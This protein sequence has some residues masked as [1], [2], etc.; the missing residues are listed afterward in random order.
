MATPDSRSPG[1]ALPGPASLLFVLA[2]SDALLGEVLSTGELEAVQGQGVSSASAL[3]I[4]VTHDLRGR[5]PC[6]CDAI[7]P[8]FEP[9]RLW[10]GVYHP[11]REPAGSWDRLDRFALSAVRN[12][13][14]WFYPTQDGHYLSWQRQLQV[15]LGPGRLVDPAPSAPSSDAPE[16]YCRDQFALLWSLLAD[17]TSLTCVGLTYAGRRID[18]PLRQRQWT[19]AATWSTFSVDSRR[20]QAL[21]VHSRQQVAAP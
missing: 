3:R 11:A 9:G 13:S 2:P 15:T 19:G 7:T 17:D 4:V 18:W 21:I 14:C 6:V 12:D 10:L 1:V 20:E 16:G 8:G 5:L